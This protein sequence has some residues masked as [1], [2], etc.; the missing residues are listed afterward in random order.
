MV[1]VLSLAREGF[2]DHWRTGLDVSDGRS[3][4]SAKGGEG[5]RVLVT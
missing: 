2:S 3:S 1:S 4:N 5:V